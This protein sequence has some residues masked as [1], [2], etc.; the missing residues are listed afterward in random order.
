MVK[1][2]RA[3]K[4]REGEIITSSVW[5]DGQWGQ[6]THNHIQQKGCLTGLLW[7][8]ETNAAG[9]LQTLSALLY[10]AVEALY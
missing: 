7:N 6:D 2:G 3:S 10:S 4:E 8:T 5:G 9:W 1:S